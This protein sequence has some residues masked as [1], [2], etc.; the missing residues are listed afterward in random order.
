MKCGRKGFV[1]SR[2]NWS[3]R[4]EGVAATVELGGDV[5][6]WTDTFLRVTS[7]H[8]DRRVNFSDV[9]KGSFPL[10]ILKTK[11]VL[12]RPRPSSLFC[13]NLAKIFIVH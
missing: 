2:F 7:I 9:Q 10:A 1:C 3:Y 13:L 4:C 8:R 6:R 5:S 11:Q 12:S